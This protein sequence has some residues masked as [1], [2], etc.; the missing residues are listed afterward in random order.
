MLEAPVHQKRE[1]WEVR[2]L[3]WAKFNASY[4]EVSDFLAISCKLDI[5]NLNFIR[6]YWPSLLRYT[7]VVWGLS[8]ALPRLLATPCNIGSTWTPLTI[9]AC[10]CRRESVVSRSSGSLHRRVSQAHLSFSHH[11]CMFPFPICRLVVSVRHLSLV[12]KG[13]LASIAI[14]CLA[15]CHQELV[16]AFLDAL[17]YRSSLATAAPNCKFSKLGFYSVFEWI[18]SSETSQDQR[19]ELLPLVN[20]WRESYYPFTYLYSIDTTGF[21]NNL[22]PRAWRHFRVLR[23]NKNRHCYHL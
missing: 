21:L 16:R 20:L 3:E 7:R 5:A 9:V 19:R 18:V 22:K 2:G 11:L 12:F 10:P 15:T 1:S 13:P 14:P 23:G 8:L 4:G 17:T 6:A